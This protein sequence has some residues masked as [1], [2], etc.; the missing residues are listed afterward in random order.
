MTVD[1]F[2]EGRESDSPYVE[3]IWRGHAGSHYTPTCP[4]DPRW[5]LLLLK[6]YGRVKVT[7]E[8]PLSRAMDKTHPEGTEWLV[9]KFRLGAFMPHLRL[10]HLRDADALLPEAASRSFWLQGAA[11]QFPGF[12]NVEAFVG[13]LVREEVL[14][15]DPVVNA[16]L[17]AQPQDISPRTVRRHFLHATGLT[18]GGIQQIERAQQAAALLGGGMSI[19]DVVA[20]A[21][22]ADQPHL[23]RSMRR[24]IG[25]TPTQIAGMR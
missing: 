14:T 24:F 7:V 20:Q 4:A 16:A 15:F 13:R 9:I 12:E 6:Q 8:G 19:L 21:G 25:Q 11:W 18:Y 5:N 3:M 17:K 22:Y 23:T 2:F 1:A 10:F